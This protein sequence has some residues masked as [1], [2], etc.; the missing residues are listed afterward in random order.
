MKRRRIY[1]GILFLCLAVLAA[2]LRTGPG[3]GYS[4]PVVDSPEKQLDAANPMWTLDLRITN[5]ETGRPQVYQWTMSATIGGWVKLECH[6][7]V[8]VTLY[9]HPFSGFPRNRFRRSVRVGVDEEGFAGPYDF[10][11]RWHPRNV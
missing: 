10:V 6:E 1:F 4:D 7:W 3:Q 5:R 2:G 11:V 9:G 8:Q